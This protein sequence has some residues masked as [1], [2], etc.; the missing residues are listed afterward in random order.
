MGVR[1]LPNSRVFVQ[2]PNEQLLLLGDMGG[3]AMALDRCLAYA[4]MAVKWPWG[5]GWRWVGCGIEGGIGGG[6]G[7][8]GEGG[9]LAWW[10]Q[11][12]GQSGK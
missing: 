3:L 9:G 2:S 4:G 7:G 11:M 8:G 10:L 12:W 1:A 5:G 6:S